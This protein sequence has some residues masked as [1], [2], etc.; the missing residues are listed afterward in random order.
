MAYQVLRI[1]VV[2]SGIL[3]LFVAIKLLKDTKGI[4]F[5]VIDSMFVVLWHLIATIIALFRQL[6]E[7]GIT[8][9]KIK[10]TNRKL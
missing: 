6:T 9:K 4:T 10:K 8:I 5:K 7:N 1:D 2:V 3:K